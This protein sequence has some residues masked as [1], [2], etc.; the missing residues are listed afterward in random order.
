MP[1]CAP[2]CGRAARNKQRNIQGV[3][4]VSWDIADEETVKLYWNGECPILATPKLKPLRSSTTDCIAS[5]SRKL[6]E[7]CRSSRLLEAVEVFEELTRESPITARELHDNP[8]IVK[9]RAIGARLRRGLAGT[10]VPAARTD[11]EWVHAEIRDP[12]VAKDFLITMDLRFAQGEEHDKLG[13]TSQMIAKVKMVSFPARVTQ[14]IALQREVDLFKKEWIKDCDKMENIVGD[15]AHQLS[16]VLMHIILAP[17]LLPFRLEEVLIRE[18]SVCSEAPVHGMLPEDR[19]PGVLLMESNPPEK[20]NHFEE[21]EV[22]AKGGRIVRMRSTKVLYITSSGA[23]NMCD[24]VAAA[25]L[26]FP[27]YRQILPLDLLKRVLIDLFRE[28]VRRLKEQVFDCWNEMEFDK[29]IAADPEFY[30][31]VAK[32]ELTAS[33]PAC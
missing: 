9:L 32:S 22:P 5:L 14:W 21:W 20:V 30:D 18:F 8:T 17:F 27:V 2:P 4:V 15:H 1:R 23:G 19:T 12:K 3:D 33:G 28:S 29:R 24:I 6:F 16:S 26:G 31:A 13:P 25:R 11:T 7:L 10:L